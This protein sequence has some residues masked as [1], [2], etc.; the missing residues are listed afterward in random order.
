MSFLSTLFRSPQGKS[1]L[2]ALFL[3]AVLGQ[4]LAL[5]VGLWV[6][7]KLVNAAADWTASQ[8]APSAAIPKRPKKF[9]PSLIPLPPGGRPAA[10]VESPPPAISPLVSAKL[11]A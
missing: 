8:A 9:T 11:I 10:F 3:A 7:Q 2:H 6:E 4:A 1:N 5:A